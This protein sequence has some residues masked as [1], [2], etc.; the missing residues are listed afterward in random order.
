MPKKKKKRI[1]KMTERVDDLLRSCEVP[2]LK[3]VSE[4]LIKDTTK[5]ERRHVL[6]ISKKTG[7]YVSGLLI[8]IGILIFLFSTQFLF[9]ELGPPLEALVFLNV[10]FLLRA[11]LWPLH[12]FALAFLGLLNTLCGLMLLSYKA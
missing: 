2:Y 10:G 8:A 4:P 9:S 12:L 5:A 11:E 1:K 6:A 7:N 3:R